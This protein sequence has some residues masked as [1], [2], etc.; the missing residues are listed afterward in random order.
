VNSTSE[1]TSHEIS[2][3]GS[4]LGWFI[5]LAVGLIIVGW[6]EIFVPFVSS[7]GMQNLVG[8]LLVISGIMY[9][10]HTFRWRL[11]ERITPGFFIGI[12]YIAFGLVFLGHPVSTIFTLRFMLGTFFLL[13]GIFK[14]AQSIR[15][16]PSSGWGWMLFSGIVSVLLALLIW[17][18]R[19]MT[20]FW[21]VGLFIGI[22]LLFTGFAVLMIALTL[23]RSVREGERFCIGGE[24][25]QA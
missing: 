16:R 4:H 19:V 10:V 9:I 13:E 11:S 18:G 3:V 1:Q 23:R 24:C 22:N 5:G 20:A 12:L 8:I 15:T 2:E 14:I 21:T 7:V 17:A 6:L 25:F